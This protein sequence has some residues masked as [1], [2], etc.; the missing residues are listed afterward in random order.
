[1]PG[2]L[3]FHGIMS[4]SSAV[5]G[6]GN[7][8]QHMTNLEDAVSEVASRHD[9][10]DF[11]DALR[12]EL[13]SGSR[14]WRNVTVEQYLEAM[15]AWVREMPGYYINRGEPVPEVPDWRLIAQILA[16]S[17]LYE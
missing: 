8:A 9:L 4:A 5:R 10:A 6:I 11:I 12:V 15:S 2:S 14:A 7:G 16:A 13:Q 17:R 3:G 1:M